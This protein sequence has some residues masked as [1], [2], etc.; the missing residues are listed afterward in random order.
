MGIGD[1]GRRWAPR[2]VIHKKRASSATIVAACNRSAFDRELGCE[3]DSLKSLQGGLEDCRHTNLNR[4]CPA[5]A[6]GAGK[7]VR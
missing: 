7:H 6:D 4:S 5:V 2:D 3:I 1:W